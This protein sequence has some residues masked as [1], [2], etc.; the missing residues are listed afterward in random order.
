MSGINHLIRFAAAAFVIALV[1]APASALR[2]GAP[3]DEL[4]D[5]EG[6]KL[7]QAQCTACHDLAEVTKFKGYY[8][9]DEWKDIVT[10]MVGYGADLKKEEIDVLVEYLAMVLGKPS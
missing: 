4:P 6:K 2:A 9:K 3:G 8:T 7:L 1:T 10:T 5:G